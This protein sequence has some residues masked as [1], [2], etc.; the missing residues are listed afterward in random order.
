MKTTVM[1]WKK[2]NYD[3]G[4]DDWME[5]MG[6]EEL[7]D[8]NGSTY[9]VAEEVENGRVDVTVRPGTGSPMPGGPG[10]VVPGTGV[11]GLPTSTIPGGLPKG[12]KML[13]KQEID[14]EESMSDVYEVWLGHE[15]TELVS[16]GITN[17]TRRP[18]KE[19]IYELPKRFGNKRMTE[20]ELIGMV[21]AIV[22]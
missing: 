16:E 11:D 22:N 5:E 4:D 3:D 9:H 7:T 17:I 6:E 1:I 2:M 13:S 20:S 21:N 19:Q 18:K 12:W 15:E 8:L 14:E 10:V